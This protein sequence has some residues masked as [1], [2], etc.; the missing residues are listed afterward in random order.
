MTIRNNK[1]HQIILLHILLYCLF[2][3][4]GT[5]AK[6]EKELPK[7][8]SVSYLDQV[9]HR[10]KKLISKKCFKDTS[11]QEK[12]FIMIEVKITHS[13]KTKARIIGTEIKNNNSLM[14]TLSIL[15]RTRFKKFKKGTIIRIYRFFVL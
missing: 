4:S 12:G 11:S 5:Q 15:N 9:I 10:K 6:S 1:I 3:N 14:C 2:Y 7:L 8:L 13:G